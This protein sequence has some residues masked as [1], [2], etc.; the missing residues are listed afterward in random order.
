MLRCRAGSRYGDFRRTTIAAV[1]AAIPKVTKI[2]G[3]L[4]YQPLVKKIV[5]L[6]TSLSPHH[7]S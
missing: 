3:G 1:H 5:P 2:C 4:V 7:T 6:H